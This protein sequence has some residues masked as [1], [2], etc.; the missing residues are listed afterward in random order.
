[1]RLGL[2][3][4]H[5]IHVMGLARDDLSALR[6]RVTAYACLVLLRVLSVCISGAP[7]KL[8]A[9]VWRVP[10]IIIS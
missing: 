9:T 6:Q 4:G 8:G 10:V 3:P 7:Q 5:D 1:M 2:G